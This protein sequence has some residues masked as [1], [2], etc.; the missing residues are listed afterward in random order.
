MVYGKR[1]LETDTNLISRLQVG[2][3]LYLGLHPHLLLESPIIRLQS[4]SAEH[5]DRVGPGL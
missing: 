5:R 4:Q 1:A 3:R 2:V